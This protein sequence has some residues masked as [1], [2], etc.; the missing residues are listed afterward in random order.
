LTESRPV[1]HPH[2]TLFAAVGA[3]Q[4]RKGV[5]VANIFVAA[6][7]LPAYNHA[8][9]TERQN[10]VLLFVVSVVALWLL[11]LRMIA[12][13]IPSPEGSL[14]EAQSSQSKEGLERQVG[15]TGGKD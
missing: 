5:H 3:K 13:L 9:T 12:A 15:R 1:T 8:D 11:L 7:C 6:F 10:P 14:A 2:S 4:F